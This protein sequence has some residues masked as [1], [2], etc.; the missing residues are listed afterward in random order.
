MLFNAKLLT[1]AL[2]PELRDVQ[3]RD[4]YRSPYDSR[5]ITA[6]G[7]KLAESCFRVWGR[8]EM[9]SK[10]T[11]GNLKEIYHLEDVGPHGRTKLKWVSEKLMGGRG[12]D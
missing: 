6:S 2:G 1:K 9:P 7:A 8:R 12:L 3:F 5:G 11:S 10:L 4:L